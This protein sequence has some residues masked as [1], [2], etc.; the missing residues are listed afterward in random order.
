MNRWRLL[1]PVLL[2]GLLGSCGAG[3]E[4]APPKP[5]ARE[6]ELRAATPATPEL[7]AQ[8]PGREEYLRQAEAQLQEVQRLVAEMQERLEKLSPELRARVTEQLQA[9][10]PKLRTARRKLQELKFAGAET[11]KKVQGELEE[12]L[13]ELKRRAEELPVGFQFKP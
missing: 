11:Y 4:P 9:L 13:K 6:P 1:I 2:L 3:E 10:E 5:S 12:L 7:K 8:P